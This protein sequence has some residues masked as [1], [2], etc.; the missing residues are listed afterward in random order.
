MRNSTALAWSVRTWPD[1]TLIEPGTNLGVPAK[2]K[3]QRPDRSLITEP[4]NRL[5]PARPFVCIVRGPPLS[6]ST[7][8]ESF[9]M[10]CPRTRPSVGGAINDVRSLR[11]RGLCLS[12]TIA[13]ADALSLPPFESL[14]AVTVALTE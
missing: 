14:E 12:G 8:L 6:T 11:T 2:S 10:S 7:K 5:R 1:S 3:R 4:R 9:T 13:L